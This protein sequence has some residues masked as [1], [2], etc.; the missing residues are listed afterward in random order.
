M[1]VGIAVVVGYGGWLVAT[2]GMTLGTLLAVFALTPQFYATC[3]ALI[4]S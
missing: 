2:G 3:G 1:S 4:A